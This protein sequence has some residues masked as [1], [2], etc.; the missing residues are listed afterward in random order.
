MRM[1]TSN[2]G[3][4]GYASSLNS[5]QKFPAVNPASSYQTATPQQLQAAGIQ[6][7]VLNDRQMKSRLQKQNSQPLLGAGLSQFE[8]NNYYT[9]GSIQS[10]SSGYTS[11]SQQQHN[12]SPYHQQI[13]SGGNSKPLGMQTA[14][15]S[16]RV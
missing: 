6:P 14:Q 9:R 11:Q 1:A 2:E 5:S 16:S 10:Q 12:L 7:V 15:V 3:P 4:R 8:D 13:L